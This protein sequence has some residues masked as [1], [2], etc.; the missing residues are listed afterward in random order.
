MMA[1]L[2]RVCCSAEFLEMDLPVLVVGILCGLAVLLNTFSV[3]G[4][5]CFLLS[6]H[7]HC[8]RSHHHFYKDPNGTQDKQVELEGGEVT[9]KPVEEE[10]CV[11][12]MKLFVDDKRPFHLQEEE[13]TP[14]EKKKEDA[15]IDSLLYAVP[16]VLVF[17]LYT[18]ERVEYYHE[19]E[20]F[21]S[22]IS[23]ECV[24]LRRMAP[25][26]S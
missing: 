14:E 8:H 5:L 1:L 21:K 15:Y 6:H 4:Y 19:Y 16:I 10:V 7:Y 3:D 20:G 22:A 11:Q 26:T 17:G 9:A 24:S 25:M 2:V 13:E 23:G 12:L 18:A